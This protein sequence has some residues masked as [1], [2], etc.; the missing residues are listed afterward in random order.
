MQRTIA[1]WDVLPSS[2]SITLFSFP[3][4]DCGAPPELDHV[5]AT[6]DG[7]SVGAMVTY[8]CIHGYSYVGGV[9][10]TACDMSGQW[11]TVNITC[12]GS[13]VKMFGNGK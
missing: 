9:N 8:S 4:V 2:E 3:E 12:T 6:F 13:Y 5:T 7:T 10:E 1:C 11:G